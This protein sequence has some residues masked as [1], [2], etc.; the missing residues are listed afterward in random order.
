MNWFVILIGTGM[1]KHGIRR[2]KKSFI[3]CY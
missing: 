1:K 2:R 3:L